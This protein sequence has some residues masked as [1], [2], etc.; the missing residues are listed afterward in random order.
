MSEISRPDEWKTNLDV[1]FCTSSLT[2]VQHDQWLHYYCY[3]LDRDRSVELQ[4]LEIRSDRQIIVNGFNIKWQ[5]MLVRGDGGSRHC[6]RGH[7]ARMKAKRSPSDV[8]KTK[9]PSRDGWWTGNLIK[10]L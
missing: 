6:S 2:R 1:S 4:F 5:T 9:R 10:E 8:V 7:V 3:A